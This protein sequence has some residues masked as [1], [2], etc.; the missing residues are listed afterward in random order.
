MKLYQSVGPNPHVVRMFIQ[1]KGLDIDNIEVDLMGGENRQADYQAKNPAGQLPALELDD[2][3]VISEITAIC[4]YLEEL[5][6]NPNLL[7]DT[8]EARAQ[9]RMW[10]RRIDLKIL[11][12]MTN[13]F[14]YAEGLPLFSSRI[15]CIPQAA[16][17]LKLI[18]QEG[19]MW[20]D[21]Q[22]GDNIF[23]TGSEFS[24]ADIMLFCFLEFGA[25]IGQ[26]YD[27]SMMANISAWHKRV[28]ARPATVES[29]H[30]SQRG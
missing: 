14:R 2:G 28:A 17:E 12:P 1:E 10:V 20:L 24:L 9:T 8:P 23:I 11:E 16:D 6:S 3:S 19:L 18:A 4:E 26:P 15:R 22:L 13:G 30:A 25:Q 7:G 21:G 27:S 29:L 5:N